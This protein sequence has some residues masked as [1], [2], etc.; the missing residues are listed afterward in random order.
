MNYLHTY[1]RLVPDMVE[2]VRNNFCQ[3]RGCVGVRSKQRERFSNAA[4]KHHFLSWL[5]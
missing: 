2:C 4:H 5:K 1:I 3:C